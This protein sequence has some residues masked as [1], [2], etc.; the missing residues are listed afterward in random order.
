MPDPQPPRHT[1]PPQEPIPREE[2]ERKSASPLIWLLL[3]IAL[4]AAGWYFY[5]QRDPGQVPLEP[6]TP[7]GDAAPIGDGSAPEPE[8]RAPAPAPAAPPPAPQA[9]QAIS[10]TQPAYPPA[11]LRAGEEGTV[12]LRV[13]VDAQGSATAVEVVQSSRSR[14]LDRAARDAV[15]NWQFSPAMENGQAIA[16]TVEIPIE[17]RTDE[18]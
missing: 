1:P 8:P 2:V 12:L 9:A 10:P 5:S 13:E 16:S 14:E 18:P 6:A 17:F 3:L 4:L 15:R 7:I 11:A